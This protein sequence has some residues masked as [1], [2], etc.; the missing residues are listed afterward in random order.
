MV[1]DI[2]DFDYSSRFLRY[3]DVHSQTPRALFNIKDINRLYEMAGYPLLDVLDPNQV[4]VPIYETEMNSLLEIIERRRNSIES[5]CEEI[6]TTENETPGN[7]V[8]L[9]DYR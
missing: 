8:H 2:N 1:T 5:I 4:V 3:C 7:V 9:D 6:S